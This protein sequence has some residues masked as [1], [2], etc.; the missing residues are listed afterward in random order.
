MASKK[1]S[2]QKTN[3]SGAAKK[4]IT[5]IPQPN[6]SNV[7]AEQVKPDKKSEVKD[8]KKAKASKKPKKNNKPNI[9][10]RAIQFIKSVFTELK[11]VSWLTGEELVKNTAVVGGMVAILTLLVWLVD[12][13]LGAMAAFLLGS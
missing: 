12:T 3:K 5:K 7:K 6:D 4:T 13:G 9:F 11:K 8:E 1:K 2:K 10:V